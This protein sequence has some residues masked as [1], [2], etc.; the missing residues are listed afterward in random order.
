MLTASKSADSNSDEL[1]IVGG[2]GGVGAVGAV[3]AGDEQE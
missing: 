2:D 3:G 1:N